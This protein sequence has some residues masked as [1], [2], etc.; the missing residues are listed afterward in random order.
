MPGKSPSSPRCAALVGPYLSGKT[1]LMEGL[2]HVCG[3]IPRKGTV[4]EKNT[5]GDASQEARNRSMSVE[6][7]AASAEFMGE[8]W[9]FLDCPGSIE[10][11]QVARA[12]LM[13]ADIAVVVCEPEVE[14]A[15]TLAPQIGRAHV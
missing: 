6:V 9:S 15:L 10:F 4:K 7:T 3:A 13:V 12:A 8:R 11:A 2:L 5:V 1:T 14:R